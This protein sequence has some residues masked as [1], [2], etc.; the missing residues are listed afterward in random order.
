MRALKWLGLILWTLWALSQPA[1]AELPAPVFGDVANHEAFEGFT[2]IARVTRGDEVLFELAKGTDAG[3]Q[4][5]D[6]ETRFWIG[7]ISKQFVGAAVVRLE[8]EGKL[9]LTDPV[10]KYIPGWP[11][12][13]LRRDGVDCTIVWLLSH[14]C[15][16]PEA[17][18]RQFHRYHVDPTRKAAFLE[19]LNGIEL[20]FTPGTDRS[21][22]NEAFNLGGILVS[23]LTN[24]PLEDYLRET[25]FTPF[26]MVN[27][28]VRT[29][30]VDAYPDRF[31]PGH[32][33][34]FLGPVRPDRWIN[35]PLDNGANIGAAGNLFATTVDLERW[36][37]GL[38]RDG[39]FRSEEA[40]ALTKS[41]QRDRSYGLGIMKREKS[42]GHRIGHNGALSPEGYSTYLIYTPE[43]DTT[44]TVLRNQDTSLGWADDIG[45]ALMRLAH[46][47][48][49]DDLGEPADGMDLVLALVLSALMCVVLSPLWP[50]YIVASAFRRKKKEELAGRFGYVVRI[51]SL[52]WMGFVLNNGLDGPWST[53]VLLFVAVCAGLALGLYRRAGQVRYA[54]ITDLYAW[55]AT[56][57][58]A[59]AIPSYYLGFGLEHLVFITGCNGV[60]WG[61][62][63]AQDRFVPVADTGDAP[64]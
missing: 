52:G 61:M 34:S 5:I 49:T 53:D 57:Y 12:D 36:M 63:V 6:A 16:I 51:I 33:A 14:Q 29:T 38:F 13:A 1:M 2:G 20:D 24:Q 60:G 22:S 10:A 54:A 42:Y 35:L 3:G 62:I 25:F 8:T 46:G 55:A 17:W 28:G 48:A 30:G 44:V 39:Q 26:G 27:T 23:T 9:S 21:Y 18:G 59:L 56:S 58:I 31:A 32:M 40:E 45:D 43:T 19:F 47:E 64:A 50:L 41:R 15:G 37:R 7:S 4:P 11:E